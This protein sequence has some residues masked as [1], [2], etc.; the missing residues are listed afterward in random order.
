MQNILKHLDI[1]RWKDLCLD[2]VKS[3]KELFNLIKNS[4]LKYRVSFSEED[5][6][7]SFKT[8]KSN[9]TYVTNCV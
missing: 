7:K 6:F 2:V 1:S 5:V 9:V 4:K 3:W 8:F